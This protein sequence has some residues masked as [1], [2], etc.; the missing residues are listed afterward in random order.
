MTL[1]ILSP[2]RFIYYSLFEWLRYWLIDLLLLNDR[3]IDLLFLFFP[4]FPL[5]FLFF[6]FSPSVSLSPPLFCSEFWGNWHSRSRGR[7]EAGRDHGQAGKRRHRAC[8]VLG[9]SFVGENYCN[10]KPSDLSCD[11][12]LWSYVLSP[13]P[14]VFLHSIGRLSKHALKSQ[15][16]K[17]LSFRVCCCCDALSTGWKYGHTLV[18]IYSIDRTVDRI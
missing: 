5:F 11:Q 2:D 18:F 10:L 15:N 17:M 4:F 14:V 8:P 3:L 16:K 13:C 1:S 7:E 9:G 6:P 12:L